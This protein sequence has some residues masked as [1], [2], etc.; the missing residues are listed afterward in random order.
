MSQHRH[1]GTLK[2]L[3][4]PGIDTERHEAHMTHTG[5]GYEPF[6]VILRKRYLSAI[7]DTHCRQRHSDRSKGH[8]SLGKQRHCKPDQTVCSRLQE[9]TSQYDTARGGRLTVRI[10]Q[11][12]M[13]RHAGQ[14]GR[15]GNKEAQHHPHAHLTGKADIQQVMI[16]KAQRTKL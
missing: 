15:K 1:N 5:V 11:P 8:R 3:L 9:H 4:I 7:Q 10:R 12:G 13:E 6:D 16:V 14:L 2:C